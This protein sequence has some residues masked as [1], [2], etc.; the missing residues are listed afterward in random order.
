LFVLLRKARL[1][2]VGA[3]VIAALFGLLPRLT[4]AVAWISGRTDVLA[5]FFVLLALVFA[6]RDRP[7]S[8]W[9][10]ALFSLLGLLAKEV[11]LAGVFALALYAWRNTRER[12]LKQRAIALAPV[13]SV[14]VAYALIRAWAI[15]SAIRPSNL[16]LGQQIAGTVEAVG[17]YAYMLVDP[18]R[19]SIQI[20]RL[21]TPSTLFVLVGLTTIIVL[22]SARRRLAVWRT[23]LDYA[24]L[25][26]FLVSIGLVLHIVPITVNVI[27]ADRFLYL[28]SIALALLLGPRI[29]TAASRWKKAPVFVALLLL[30]LFAGTLRASALWS[31]EIALWV[32]TYRAQRIDNAM[33]RVELGNVYLRAGLHREAFEVY[34]TADTL[35]YFNYL[36]SRHNMGVALLFMGQYDKAEQT[37]REVV[38]RDPETPK[39]WLTLARASLAS[40]NFAA[41]R[42]ALGRA[43]A[44]Y[45]E[46]DEAKRVLADIERL[47]TRTGDLERNAITPAEQIDKANLLAQLGQQSDALE[48]GAAAFA[49]AVPS[50]E[51]AIQLLLHSL[52]FGTPEIVNSYF[53]AYRQAFG[54]QAAPEVIEVVRIRQDRVAR[55]RQEFS[56]LGLTLKRKPPPSTGKHS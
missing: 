7:V 28:P 29:W 24:A 53:A 45:P 54:E 55:L 27:A 14:C 19:P 33:S 26:L 11:A 22:V 37:L 40:K 10:A 44:L 1:S 4:E 6:T 18:W 51:N 52:K 31:D 43:F 5:A 41:A 49:Q 3:A 32:Q 25:A 9:I 50:R 13:A 16:S 35:D 39:F 8:N 48:L 17:R 20:G 15:G 56:A 2:G 30:S 34:K 46:F 36:M 38:R 47:E 42:Q 21:G 23:P 12:S